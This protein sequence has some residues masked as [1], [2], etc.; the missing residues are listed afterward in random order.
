MANIQQLL[1]ELEKAKNDW[2]LTKSELA[3][4]NKITWV[5][6]ATQIQNVN[7]QALN[8][9]WKNYEANAISTAAKKKQVEFDAA[10][11]L[12]N[13][14]TKASNIK[15]KR[16]DDT[17]Q[18]LEWHHDDYRDKQDQRYKDIQ[19]IVD[20]Q[21]RIANRQANMEAASAGRYWDIYSD[22][23]KANIKND[24][25]NRYGQNIANA[26]QYALQNNRA[27]D[28]DL[29]Q[30]GER[31]V[32][33]R[34][35][36]DAFKDALLDKNNA[37]ILDA[38]KAARDG[39]KKALEDVENFYQSFVRKKAE[40]ENK[41]SENTE[42]REAFEKE[43]ASLNK[44]G[45]A[46]M[47]RD[48]LYNVPWYN[49]VVD[50]IP[51]LIDKYKWMSLSELKGKML[52]IAEYA[53][54][55]KQFAEQV[56]KTPEKD[57]SKF[58]NKLVNQYFI[59]GYDE[60]TRSDRTYDWTLDQFEKDSQDTDWRNH[61]YNENWDSDNRT[62]DWDPLEA[63]RRDKERRDK[64]EAERRRQQYNQN[65]NQYNNNNSWSQWSQYDNNPKNKTIKDLPWNQ[66][67]EIVR[68]LNIIK[69]TS[70]NFSPDNLET[71]ASWISKKYWVTYSEALDV[72]R[73]AYRSRGKWWPITRSSWGWSWGSW[74]WWG[75]GWWWGWSS[76]WNP[77]RDAWGNAL[78]V[79]PDP[80]VSIRR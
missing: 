9:T 41:R 17:R 4:L 54:S 34:N 66:K 24:V 15:E 39:D 49:L 55:W 72:V 27:I 57:R 52:K 68:I 70:R 62:D 30:V 6:V 74:G 16:S 18:E 8:A 1:S 61:T 19:E 65:W 42:R 22:W 37:Y 20:T 29:L 50:R 23:A 71:T 59:R 79:R 80:R 3:Y 7:N 78:E 12:T 77:R 33:D 13:I 31:S 2:K 56:L 58:E 48:Q 35:T 26:Q 75:W 10:D 73:A 43:F 60:L 67:D 40:E 5:N 46:Q 64:E 32:A 21:T 38:I 14:E 44:Q 45:K 53:L 28:G 36:R 11:K 76:S 25:I 47:L 69:D 51:E 63:A